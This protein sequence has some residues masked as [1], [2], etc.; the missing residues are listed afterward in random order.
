ME[1][2]TLLDTISLDS[3]QLRE[4]F[5][6]QKLSVLEVFQFVNLRCEVMANSTKLFPKDFIKRHEDVLRDASK[7]LQEEMDDAIELLTEEF[8]LKTTE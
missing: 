4:K 3:Q 7:L 8:E 1:K 2:I 5:L 6:Q